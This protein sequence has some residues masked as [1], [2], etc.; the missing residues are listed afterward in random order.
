[1][2][3]SGSPDVGFIILE[4]RRID[5]ITTNLKHKISQILDE[6]TAFGAADQTHAP[7]GQFMWEM[8]MEGFYNTGVGLAQEGLELTGNQV[9]MYSL[10]GNAI[11][12]PFTGIDGPHGSITTTME[13]AKLHRV[14]ADFKA[15]F[16]PEDMAQSI[17]SFP[18]N[19]LVQ[20]G[21]QTVTDVGPTNLA[22]L[23]WNTFDTDYVDQATGWAFGFLG[24]T[25]VDID[26]AGDILFTIQDSDNDIGY[27]D[28]IVFT[29]ATTAGG[30]TGELVSQVAGAGAAEIERYT[31]LQYEF[32][33]VSGASRTC[34]FACGLIRT[35][36]A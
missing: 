8:D 34:T 2:A 1:M 17:V 13:R 29:V 4:G 5:N 33:G 23:D 15:S 19:G 18:R 22:T 14:K 31:Q 26:G 6:T 3:L 10:A 9:L 36:I 25:N 16:G 28:L 12:D 7:V 35:L 21:L 24:V 20:A 27:N 11:G 32:Q 30:V